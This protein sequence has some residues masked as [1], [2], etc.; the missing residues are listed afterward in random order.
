MFTLRRVALVLISLV[1]LSTEP[2]GAETWPHRVV[3]IILPLPAGIGTD[4]AARLFAEGLTKR[5][6]QQVVV[7]N[8]PGA[9]GI[10]GVTHFVNS[11]DD[12][13]LLFSFAGPISIN[14]LIHKDLPYDPDRDLVPIASAIDNYFAIAAATSLRV[15]SVDALVALA[16]KEPGKLNWTASPGLPQYIF[17]TLQQVKGLEMIYIPYRD[18]NYALQDFG[19][20]RV[21]AMSSSITSLLPLAQRGKA[22][23]LIVT[24][25]QRSPLAEDVPTAREAGFPELSFDGV[26]GFYGWRD[27][28]PDLK[29]R[30]AA[31]VRAVAADSAMISQLSKIGIAVRTGT[32]AEFVAEIADQRTRIEAIVRS[33]KLAK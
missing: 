6:K 23:L 17:A 30:I 25:R 24:S 15:E 26:V 7:E 18:S 2:C 11:H 10:A 20:G 32:P 12:H 19:E 13:T 27:I 28:A 1:T 29:E 4:V 9:D 21:Q 14:P 22:K 3:R 5:W 16:R 8:H 33:T 31:D